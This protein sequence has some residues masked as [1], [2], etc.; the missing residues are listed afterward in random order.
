MYR[1]RN[2]FIKPLL[3]TS[4][5]IIVGLNEAISLKYTDKLDVNKIFS[6]V[7]S[8]W[9]IPNFFKFGFKLI[10]FAFIIFCNWIVCKII[11]I[12]IKI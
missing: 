4:L 7:K 10:L 11:F 2:R 5:L 3:T 1:K 8:P 9:T 12:G 6:G